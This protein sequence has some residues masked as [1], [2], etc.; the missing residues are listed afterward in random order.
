MSANKFGLPSSMQPGTI[1]GLPERV[2]DLSLYFSLEV[3][4]AMFDYEKTMYSK[5]VRNYWMVME[6]GKIDFLSVI[7]DVFTVFKCMQFPAMDNN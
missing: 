1:G 7:T 5:K 2:F 6:L 4:D 3:L